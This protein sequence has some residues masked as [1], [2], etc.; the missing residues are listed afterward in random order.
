MKETETVAMTL[1][2]AAKAVPKADRVEA[3][4]GMAAALSR[5]ARTAVAVLAAAVA[6]W[7]TAPSPVSATVTLTMN[8]EMPMAI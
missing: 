2:I 4:A 5:V 7:V 1:A 6:L 3:V 8:A